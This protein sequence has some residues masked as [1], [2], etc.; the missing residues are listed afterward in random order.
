[1]VFTDKFHCFVFWSWESPF[2]KGSNTVPTFFYNALIAKFNALFIIFARMKSQ[3]KVKRRE[4][5]SCQKH[6]REI[7]YQFRDVVIDG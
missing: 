7:K 1:M 3:I 6:T 2:K 4:I 5:L